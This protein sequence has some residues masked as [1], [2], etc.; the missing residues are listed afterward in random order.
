MKQW[1]AVQSIDN[2]DV[3]YRFLSLV[4]PALGD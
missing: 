2:T 4:K 3:K 1:R